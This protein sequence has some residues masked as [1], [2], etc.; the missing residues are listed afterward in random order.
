MADSPLGLY[1]PRLPR[2]IAEV[3]A[4][5]SAAGIVHGFGGALAMAYATHLPRATLDIDINIAVPT[6][7]AR[8]VLAALPVGTRWDERN[9]TEIETDGQ[10]RTIWRDP[11]STDAKPV[12]FPIDL[13]FPQAEFHDAV[14]AAIRWVE[15]AGPDIP[16]ISPDHI[17]VFKVLFNRSKDWGD[18]EAAADNDELDWPEIQRLVE[19]FTGPDSGQAQRLARLRAEARKT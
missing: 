18:L 11:E 6:E 8:E 2:L 5:L 15:W 14:A 4:G 10:T 3:S 9:V 19:E 12:D 7:R 1:V 13:F 16:V 17:V